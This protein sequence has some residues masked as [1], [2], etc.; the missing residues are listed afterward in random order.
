MGAVRVNI[1]VRILVL[2]RSLINLAL[3]IPKSGRHLSNPH[4]CRWLLNADDGTPD[5]IV[6]FAA[7]VE[8]QLPTYIFGK[9]FSKHIGKLKRVMSQGLANPSR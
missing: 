1:W 3:I 2:V 5:S 8:A 9:G 6:S 4:L 7:G